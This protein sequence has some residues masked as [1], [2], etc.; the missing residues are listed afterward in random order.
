MTEYQQKTGIVLVEGAEAPPD[1]EQRLTTIPELPGVYLMKDA[2]GTVIYVGKAKSLRA[3][4]RTYFRGGDGRL[5]IGQLIARVRSIDTIMT[6]T[7]YQALALERELIAKHR[8]R[9]NVRLKDDRTYLSIRVDPQSAWPRIE[10][11]RRIE[12][13]G[14]KYFGPYSYGHELRTMLE[15]IKRVVPL[16]TCS[17]TVFFNRQRPCLE[18][19]IHRCA[20]PCCMPVDR[21]EYG[22]W[23][24]QAIS[25]LEGKTETLQQEL[26]KQMEDASAQLRFE[27]AAILRDRLQ[28]LENLRSGQAFTSFGGEDRDVFALY[29][30]EQLAALS[31]VRIR[32]GRMVETLNYALSDVGIEDYAILSSALEQFY[33][34][35]REV[36]EEVVLPVELMEAEALI[37]LL[38]ERRGARVQLVVPQRGVKQRVLALAQLNARQHYVS[39]FEADRRGVELSKELARTLGL[40][41]VPRRIECV[42]I[43]NL[44]GSDIVGA[45]VVFFDGLPDKRSYKRYRISCQTKPDDFAAIY[46]VVSRRLSRGLK[47]ENL[48][49]LLI[50]DGGPQ[51]LAKALQARDELKVPLEIISLAKIRVERS[52]ARIGTDVEGIVRQKPERVFKEGQEE[53][54]ALEGGA[55]VTHFIQRIRDEVHR[56]VITYHR[57]SRAQRVMASVLDGIPGLGFERRKRLLKEFGSVRALRAVSAE[58]IAARARIPLA[59]AQAVRE[60]VGG[61]SGD[62]T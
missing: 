7:E 27:E 43:S 60:A 26:E 37:D 57:Q 32:G 31:V 54:I 46:E 45:L 24:K 41:Q 62:K 17:D 2:A 20:G 8:P 22:L 39:S 25:I 13:D 47:E 30:E 49:D 48:P 56:F 36:P 18:F 1:I 58:D 12:H 19:Q 3:R 6:G 34:S 50:I 29:R 51:Q 11:V 14:A 42:D 38:S 10:L 55:P 16:R 23:V 40:S 35:G 44:Q 4:V 53:P 61:S 21:E 52:R 59:V 33:R 28:T 15:I 9:Y 5:Q